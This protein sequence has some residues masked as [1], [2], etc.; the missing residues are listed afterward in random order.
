[1]EKKISRNYTMT[2]KKNFA[3]YQQVILNYTKSNGKIK[4]NNDQTTP[5]LPLPTKLAQLP[6]FLK[7]K[8]IINK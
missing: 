7:T 4:I 1:M 3:S 5:K 8:K 2:N 6:G